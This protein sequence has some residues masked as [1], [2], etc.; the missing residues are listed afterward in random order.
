VRGQVAD[1]SCHHQPAS[2]DL[3]CCGGADGALLLAVPRLKRLKSWSVHRQPE[4]KWLA[5]KP[6]G[7]RRD[8]NQQLNHHRPPFSLIP[9]FLFLYID[10]ASLSISFSR[11]ACMTHG[12]KAA[13][14]LVNDLLLLLVYLQLAT[15]STPS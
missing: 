15:L 4:R 12:H 14:T 10:K 2:A 7:Q 6:F 5:C 8:G 13:S 3:R 1:S 9:W 11:E